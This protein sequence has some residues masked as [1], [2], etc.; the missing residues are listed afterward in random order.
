MITFL[1]S[2]SRAEAWYPALCTQLSSWDSLGKHPAC[3]LKSLVHQFIHPSIYPPIHPS[4]HPFIQ[5]IPEYLFFAVSQF[6]N[7]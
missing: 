4:I 6:S 3:S 5:A 1:T 2:S 7:Q